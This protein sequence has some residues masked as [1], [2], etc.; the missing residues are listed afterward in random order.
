MFKKIASKTPDKNLP[1]QNQ[2]VVAV[3]AVIVS[4]HDA[5]PYVL[6]TQ[7]TDHSLTNHEGEKDPALPYGPFDPDDDRT[8]EQGMRRWVE[9]QT[10]VKLG[11][12]EQLYTFGNRFRNPAEVQGGKR[13][14]SVS[15]LALTNFSEALAKQTSWQKIYSFFPWEDWRQGAPEVINRVIRPCLQTWAGEATGAE[16]KRRQE[17]ITMAF[18][19]DNDGFDLERVHAR[20]ELLY[21]ASLSVEA[22]R[23]VD[24]CPPEKR[25]DLPVS[26]RNITKESL[27]YSARKLGAPLARDHRRML[28]TTLE[29]LRGKIKYRPLVFELLPDKFTLLQLQ[30]TVESLSGHPVHKQNFRRLVLSTGLVEDTGAMET[31][32]RGRPASLFTFRK[33]VMKERASHGINLPQ[34]K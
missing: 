22:L 26:R 2:L 29:R 13:V 28:A 1:S 7:H 3:D 6:I 21:E 11:Y 27:L 5:V 8:L 33:D 17:R 14:L 4:V 10:G 24:N 34:S 16:N 12:V 30:Q 9:T 32:S 31:Q 19:R 20:Y 25:K 18:G 23:D 15:Y